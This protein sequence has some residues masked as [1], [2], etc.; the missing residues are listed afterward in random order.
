MVNILNTYKH[1]NMK[2]AEFFREIQYMY[3]INR[4]HLLHMSC[5]KSIQ[6]G[7]M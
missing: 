3:T 4:S 5:E 2:K 7:D 6:S 1:E